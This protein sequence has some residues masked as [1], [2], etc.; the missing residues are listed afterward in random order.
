MTDIR[1]AVDPNHTLP[2]VELRAQQMFEWDYMTRE[3]MAIVF[4]GSRVGK[5]DI[6]SVFEVDEPRAHF[7][8]IDIERGVRGRGIG[9]AAYVLAIE[10]SHEKGLHFETQNWSIKPGSK[11]IWDI[12]AEKGVA[13]VI[14][15]FVPS[16]QYPD[17]FEG[18]LRVPHSG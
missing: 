16:N 10:M 15:P 8:G 6:V 18:K 3:K 2:D 7:D 11:R 17:R 13:Q 5:C 14:V 1:E 12:L 9:L 4:A